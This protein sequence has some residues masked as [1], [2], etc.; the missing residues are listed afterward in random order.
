MVVRLFED[1]DAD[2]LASPG[3]PELAVA[4]V[5]TGDE[6]VA[7]EGLNLSLAAEQ[8]RTFLVTGGFSQRQGV[9]SVAVESG[10]DVLATG[11]VT[12]LGIVVSGAP[13][14][15]APQFI[16]IPP[17]SGDSGGCAASPGSRNGWVGAFLLLA[18]GLGLV[19]LRRRGVAAS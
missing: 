5:S 19:A 17:S 16:V 12:Q 15:G 8:V 18:L 3:D 1:L 14:L 9:F 13:I 2:G 4:V 11:Q 7:F 10:A 6:W